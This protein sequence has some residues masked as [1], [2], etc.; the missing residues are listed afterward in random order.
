[1]CM[2]IHSVC[3]L[4]KKCVEMCDVFL[5]QSAQVCTLVTISWNT[6]RKNS[7]YILACIECH[8]G[9][10]MLTGTLPHRLHN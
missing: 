9:V 8:S 10:G 5:Y 6:F 7:V 3:G 4:M 1:M 2:P